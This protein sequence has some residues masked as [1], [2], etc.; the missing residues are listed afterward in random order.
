[1]YVAV[2]D[3]TVLWLGYEDVLSGVK[4]LGINSFELIVNRDLKERPHTDMG[5]TF[6]LGFDLSTEKSR[7]AVAE[8]LKAEGISVCALLVN[9]DFAR[10]DIEA[11]VRWIV[12]A[13]RAA[14]ELGVGVVRINPVMRVRPNV[15]EEDYARLTAKCIREVISRTAGLDVSLGME[16]HGRVGNS[17]EYIRKVIDLVGSERMGLTL[18]TGNFYWYGYPLNEIYE[19]YEEFAPYVKHTHVKNLSFTE[20]RRYTRREPGEGYPKTAAPLYE[21]DIDL[22]RAVETLRRAGYDGDLTVEDESLGN[23]PK[24]L[25]PTIIRRDIE[26]L[27]GLI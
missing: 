10:E 27:K 2:R 3:F 1:M 4:D 9:N 8:T 25:R 13:C 20:E 5:V 23:Y 22:R 15:S 12:R 6:S 16:N 21:G 26:H 17:R 11:E 7:M 14:S 24:N 19:I 18:D